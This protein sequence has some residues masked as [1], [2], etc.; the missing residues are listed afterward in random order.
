VMTQR[1]CKKLRDQMHRRREARSGA[2]A[3]KAI[4]VS[5]QEAAQV[6]RLRYLL[7]HGVKEGL[8]AHAR[9]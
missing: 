3:T 2:D 7:A 5:E 9:D 8:V 1:A 6:D 4:P